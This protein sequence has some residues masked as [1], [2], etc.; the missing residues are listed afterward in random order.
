MYLCG[1]KKYEMHRKLIILIISVLTLFQVKGQTPEEFQSILNQFNADS[2]SRTVHDLA[3]FQNRFCNNTPQGN[4]AVAEYL[5][6][7]LREYGIEN[8]HVDSFQ[9]VGYTWATGQIDRYF[10]NVKGEILGNSNSLDQYIVGAHLDAISID[11]HWMLTPTAPGADDNASGCAVFVEIA[12][13]FHENNFQPAHKIIFMGWDAEEIGL[14]GSYNDAAI[15]NG[16]G[17]TSYT[18]VL[19]ND[20][21]ANQPDNLPYKID[22]YQYDNAVEL[23]EVGTD[24]LERFTTI[25]PI[26]PDDNN[27]MREYSDSWAYSQ[28]GCKAI[29]AIEHYFTENYHTEQDLPQYLNYDFAKEV[30]KYNFALLFH[31]CIADLNTLGEHLPELSESI[32]LYPNPVHSQCYIRSSTDNSIQNV[33]IL[34]LSGKI[35]FQSTDNEFETVHPLDLS[36][37]PHGLF[38]LKIDTN[39]GTVYKKIIK[40]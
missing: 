13:I 22:L 36:F 6:Q 11:E 33:T 39:Q 23:H 17:E 19:N 18:T 38:M 12:R 15:R 4:R 7:R 29:F 5:V 14:V 35:I 1:L 10:Y 3:A 34:D 9:Y 32:Q 27:V 26:F 30:A 20:M 21:V 31:Y 16:L 8:A 2:I 40:Q 28:A 25:T 37:L 24:I